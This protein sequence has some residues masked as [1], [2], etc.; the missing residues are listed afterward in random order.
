M[1]GVS[2]F[3]PQGAV[4]LGHRRRRDVMR[5]LRPAALHALASL[6]RRF[7][8]GAGGDGRLA[9]ERESLPPIRWWQHVGVDVGD[10]LLAAQPV[11][12]GYVEAPPVDGGGLDHLAVDDL[13]VGPPA[14]DRVDV[15][16]TKVI[17]EPREPALDGREARRRPQQRAMRGEAFVVVRADFHA[18]AAGGA[19]LVGHAVRGTA[20][21]ILLPLLIAVE[22]DRLGVGDRVAGTFARALVALAAGILKAEIDRLFP[23]ER[24]AGGDHGGLRAWPE[25]R[26][27]HRLADARHLTQARQHDQR[28]LD[29]V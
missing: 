20:L 27:E 6:R 8:L 4:S 17:V 13:E 26:I 5:W 18:A 24:H 1:Q 9:V 15:A 12:L 11:A 3:P 21:H 28:R 2:Y 19:A 25:E 7:Q 10:L 14:L 16:A 23:F 29:D 22:H